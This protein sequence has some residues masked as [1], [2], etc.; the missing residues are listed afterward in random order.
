MA[1]NVIRTLKKILISS[2]TYILQMFPG[3]MNPEQG[4]L[5]M[6]IS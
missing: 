2:V 3:V 6:T 1:G 4:S 5:I